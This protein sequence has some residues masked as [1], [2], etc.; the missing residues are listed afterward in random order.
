MKLRFFK[1]TIDF[2][3][4]IVYTSGDHAVCQEKCNNQIFYWGWPNGGQKKEKQI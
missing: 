2:F 4:K 1:S 3:E